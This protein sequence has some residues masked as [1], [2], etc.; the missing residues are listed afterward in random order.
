MEKFKQKVFRPDQD[1]DLQIVSHMIIA[2]GQA[3]FYDWAINY[4]GKVSLEATQIKAA[5]VVDI[6]GGTTDIVTITS[7]GHL[8]ITTDN[9]RCFTF[10]GFGLIN[11]K[12]EV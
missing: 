7:A 11:L 9:S 3:A 1:G 6:G 5:L 4:D 10:E 8:N 12:D 2:E